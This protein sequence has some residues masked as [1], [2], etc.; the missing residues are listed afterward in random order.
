MIAVSLTR[1][2]Q[3]KRY[4][5]R[6]PGSDAILACC[7]PPFLVIGIHNV[8]KT[9]FVRLVGQRNKADGQK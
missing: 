3:P 6:P 9:I 2:V 5:R 8:N 7:T 4:K 1:Y